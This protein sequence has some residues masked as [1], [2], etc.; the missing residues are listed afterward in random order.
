MEFD[1]LEKDIVNYNPKTEKD[2]KEL[3]GLLIRLNAYKEE[4]KEFEELD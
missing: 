2:K 1:E 3:D 4:L